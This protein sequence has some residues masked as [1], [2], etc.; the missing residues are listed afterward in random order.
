MQKYEQDLTVRGADGVVSV[1]AGAS[2]RVRSFPLLADVVIYSA[3]DPASAIGPAGTTVTTEADGHFEFYAPN[4]H[5]QID[6]SASGIAPGSLPDILLD[7]PTDVAPVIVSEVSA[8]QSYSGYKTGRRQRVAQFESTTGYTLIGG[9]T[10]AVNA[11]PLFGGVQNALQITTAA[12]VAA[13][14]EKNPD[15]FTALT[16]K[17]SLRF[18]VADWTKVSSVSIYLSK[19]GTYTNFALYQYNIAGFPIL[20]KNGLHVIDF[21]GDTADTNLSYTGGA[22]SLA[23]NP[24]VRWKIRITPVAGQVA[25]VTLGDMWADAKARPKLLI[26]ADDGYSSWVD[27]GVPILE[28]YGLRFTMNLIGD[29][30]FLGQ[31]GNINAARAAMLLGRGHDIQVHGNTSLDTINT[32]GGIAAVKADIALNKGVVESIRGG[33][34]AKHYTYPNGVYAP[35]PNNQN[36]VSFIQAL[37]DVG[38]VTARGTDV[39]SGFG[40]DIDMPMLTALDAAESGNNQT[41]LYP[42]LFR[43]PIIGHDGSVDTPAKIATRLDNVQFWGGTAVLMFHRCSGGGTLLE[44]SAANLTTI[45][46]GIAAR[47]DAGTMDVITTQEWYAGLFT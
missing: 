30:V 8:I 16:K 42:N 24:I 47:I 29:P 43:L 22:F 44:V 21:S 6:Y 5:Y 40:T 14:I 33:I 11:T 36:D 27:T 35:G 25:V 13:E 17:V 45:C 4:G 18:H 38:F 1:V 37:K 34:L 7:D 10:T 28:F 31:A 26:V 20:H 39:L 9:P 32:A 12:G 19:D 2:I 23:T 46:A 3:N 15:N 41:P